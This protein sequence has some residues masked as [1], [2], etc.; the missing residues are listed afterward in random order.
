MHLTNLALFSFLSLTLDLSV[1]YAAKDADLKPIL[2]KPGKQVVDEKFEGAALGKNWSVQKGDWQVKDGAVAGQEKASDMHPGVLTLKE[3]H[4]DSMVRISFKLDGAKFFDLSLNSSKGHLFRAVITPESI[5]LSKDK[6]K[7]DAASKGQ[8]L[9][10]AS[11]KFEAGQWYTLQLEARGDKLALQTD[12]GVKIEAANPELN[13]EKTGYRF[14]VK[15]ATVQIAAVKA[16]D[17]E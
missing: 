9:G 1:A 2:A 6:D 17:V 15:G 12:S 8:Q 13:V 14:V 10:K 3:P 7:N 5:T 11:T 4:R 16:W